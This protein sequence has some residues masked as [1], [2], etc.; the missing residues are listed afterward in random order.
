M[1]IKYIVVVSHY[2]HINQYINVYEYVVP[3]ELCILQ[4]KYISD[5]CL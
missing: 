4:H 1:E 2:M 3:M 5:T